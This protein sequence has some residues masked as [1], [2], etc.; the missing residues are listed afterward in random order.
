MIDIITQP[1]LKVA[2]NRQVYVLWLVGL[3]IYAVAII[4]LVIVTGRISLLGGVVGVFLAQLAINGEARFKK[5]DV[6]LEAQDE[7]LYIAGGKEGFYEPDIV[8]WDRLERISWD[9]GDIV[10]HRVGDQPIRLEKLPRIKRRQM[11][12]ALQV[13]MESRLTLIHDPD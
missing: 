6:F 9:Q 5:P 1:K 3:G 10:V 2:L 13:L 4:V 8:D 12:E 7:G 11:Y